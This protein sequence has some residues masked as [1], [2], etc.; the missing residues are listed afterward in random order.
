MN[1]GLSFAIAALQALI[2]IATVVGIIVAP[3]T[4]AWFIEGDGQIEWIVALK[5]AVYAFLLACGVPI[6]FASGQIVGFS[7][8][9]FYMTAL[10]LGLTMVIAM[11]AIRIGHRLSASSS[12]WPA[13]LGG[14]VAFGG[15]S[16]GLSALAADPAVLVDQYAPIYIPALLFG[17]L[18]VIASVSGPRFELFEGANGPEAR[19]RIWLRSLAAGAY[20][21]LH[22][23]IR[24]ALNPGVRVGLSVVA[25]LI[26]TS[27]VLIALALGFGWVQVIGFYQGLGLSVLG[28]VML[29]LGQLA[30]LPNLIVYGA[31]WISGAGFAIGNGS[32]VSPFATELGPI[33]ALPVFAAVPVGGSER[34]LLFILVPIIASLLATLFVAKHADQLR[35]EYGTRLTGALSLSFVAAL[36]ASIVTFL[37]SSL[38]SGSFGPGRL[39]LVGADSVVFSAVIFV[40]VLIPSFIA[41]LV[42]AKPYTDASERK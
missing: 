9:A 33:P 42:I 14:A 35:W 40:E 31:A 4:L 39:G 29:T 27:S 37:I 32:Y 13:W 1:R 28:G 38:A 22:W 6:G 8:D 36:S 19:E 30:V 25:T 34:G 3:L 16:Y 18:L 7:F 20:S 26:L 15:I 10:P 5:V 21:K 17:S 41:A 12:L 23:S 2:I 24:T 11:M